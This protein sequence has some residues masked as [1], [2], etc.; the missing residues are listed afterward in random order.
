MTSSILSETGS[1]IITGGNNLNKN[2]Y[3]PSFHI[4]SKGWSRMG[5]SSGMYPTVNVSTQRSNTMDSIRSFEPNKE[6]LTKIGDF[7]PLA[8]SFLKGSKT[9]SE[10][11]RRNPLNSFITSVL[12]R[13]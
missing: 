3:R 2:Q 11:S 9:I 7:V 8:G 10:W 1:N 5:W 6:N 12:G 4:E 13:I